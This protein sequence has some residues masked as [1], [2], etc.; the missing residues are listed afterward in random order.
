MHEPAV[1]RKAVG[2]SVPGPA[3]IMA[4]GRPVP[5]PTGMRHGVAA[6]LRTDAA[7]HIWEPVRRPE[8]G[9]AGGMIG[10]MAEFLS[11]GG[12][13]AFVWPAYA[14]TA[15]VMVGLLV[16]TL[17][18]LRRREALLRMLEDTRPRRRRERPGAGPA[19]EGNGT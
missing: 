1:S 15:L 6:A 17:R 14:I 19:T 7:D 3:D 5:G 9:A 11:M 4:S 16:S 12:Y 18:G 8:P 10:D 2:L 13:A